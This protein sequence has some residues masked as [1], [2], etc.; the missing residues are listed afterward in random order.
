MTVYLTA[1]DILRINEQH[2]GPDQLRDF[3]SDG[4]MGTG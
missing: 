1:A 4:W 2:V 3:G